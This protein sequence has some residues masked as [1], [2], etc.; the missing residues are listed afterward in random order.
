MFEHPLSRVSTE[1]YTS[2]SGAEARLLIASQ[3]PLQDVTLSLRGCAF[4]NEIWQR[5]LARIVD[6]AR[7]LKPRTETEPTRGWEG[8]ELREPEGCLGFCWG[9]KESDFLETLPQGK[10]DKHGCFSPSGLSQVL[11]RTSI[12]LPGMRVLEDA[13]DMRDILFTGQLSLALDGRKHALVELFLIR[14]TPHRR[15]S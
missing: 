3:D 15:G 1:V 14:G 6:A 2:N 11:Y 9:P 12:H 5:W 7:I 13:R 4:R 10:V 8:L